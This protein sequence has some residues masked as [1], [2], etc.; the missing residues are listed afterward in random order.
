L[1]NIDTNGTWT[2][3]NNRYESAGDGPTLTINVTVGAGN[4]ELSQK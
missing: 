4:V 2:I 3:D 1:A